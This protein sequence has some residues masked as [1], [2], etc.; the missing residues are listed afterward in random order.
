MSTYSFKDFT[1]WNFKGSQEYT[2]P[3]GT[4]IDRSCFSQEHPDSDIFPDGMTGVTF[5][6]CNLDNVLIP[7]GNTLTDC[8]TR[9]FAAQNDGKDWIVDSNNQPVSPL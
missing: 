2:F 3:P 4:T 5:R 6:S 7:P 9:R 1:G 8:T